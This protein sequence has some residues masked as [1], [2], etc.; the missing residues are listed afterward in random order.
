MGDVNCGLLVVDRWTHLDNTRT[1][2]FSMGAVA[3]TTDEIDTFGSCVYCSLDV[4]GQFDEFC[5]LLVASLFEGVEWEVP[6]QDGNEKVEKGKGNLIGGRGRGFWKAELHRRDSGE[7]NVLCAQ[8][9]AKLYEIAKKANI[10]RMG[11]MCADN[12]RIR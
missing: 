2:S 8:I 10:N 3:R 7:R 5:I 1:D 4:C 11:I 9:S 6:I 12:L